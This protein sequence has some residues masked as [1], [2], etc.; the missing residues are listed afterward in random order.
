MDE[1]EE[2]LGGELEGRPSTV[3]G[4]VGAFLGAL[5]GGIIWVV[6]NQFGVIAAIAGYA[7][8]FFAYRGYAKFGNEMNLK[9]AIIATLISIIV[10]AGAHYICWAI[11]IYKVF[12]EDYYI[13]FLDAF[14]AVPSIAA[15]P[16]IVYD[17][18][19]DFLIGL[20]F[21]AFGAFPYI[22]GIMRAKKRE[23]EMPSMESDMSSFPNEQQSDDKEMF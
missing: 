23:T 20:V 16:E 17:F 11:D 4:T 22:G 12:S 13:T 8:I 15:D 2:R 19:R 21:I 14:L 10:L 3:K 6:I 9:G 1:M 5:L 18:L 7:I